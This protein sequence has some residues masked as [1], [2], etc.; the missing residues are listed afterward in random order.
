[1]LGVLWLQKFP[2]SQDWV[3]LLVW[4]GAEFCHQT[5]YSSNYPLDP[6][7]NCL[8]QALDVLNLRLCGKMNGSIKSPLLVT[9]TN[10]MMWT[11]YFVFITIST[12]C[13]NRTK[14]WL[15]FE[16][17]IWSWQKFFSSEKNQSIFD[18]RGC[19]S[20]FESFV[21]QSFLLS[22]MACNKN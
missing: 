17:T 10:T 21:V 19:L 5:E 3:F 22:F 16:F 18:W 6:G 11:G 15:F 12:F 14:Q 20:L 9:T 8:L 2:D 13:R 7:Q 4:H 1:M